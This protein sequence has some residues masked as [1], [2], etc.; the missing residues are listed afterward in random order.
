[1]ESGRALRLIDKSII[2]DQVKTRRDAALRGTMARNV[3]LLGVPIAVL[4]SGMLR[5][6]VRGESVIEGEF[7]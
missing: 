6:V 1:M 5:S 2:S 4:W 7:P 3:R